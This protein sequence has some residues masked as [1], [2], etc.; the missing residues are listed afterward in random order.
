MLRRNIRQRNVLLQERRRR[1]A[2][3]ISNLAS[4]LVQNSIS[5]AT[6]STLHHLQPNQRL[7]NALISSL[8]KRRPT[9]E[10]RL[11][12]FAETIQPR[13]P[14]IDRVRNLVSVKRQLAFEPK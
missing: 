5:V 3:D 8:R 11:L 2:A 9:D 1:S 6:D 14:D 12:H 13:L 10:F 7:S 4:A